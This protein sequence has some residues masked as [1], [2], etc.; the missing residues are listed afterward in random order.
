MWRS[1]NKAVR[2][3]RRVREVRKARNHVKREGL[4]EAGRLELLNSQFLS[5]HTSIILK[6]DFEGKERFCQYRV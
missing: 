5:I 6:A 3:P 1:V 2:K 4:R